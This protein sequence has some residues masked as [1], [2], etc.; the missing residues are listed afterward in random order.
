MNTAHSKEPLTMAGRARPRIN[1]VE[2]MFLTTETID[3]VVKW[4]GGWRAGLVQV[5][6]YSQLRG[7]YG[8][9]TL[10]HYLVKESENPRHFREYSLTE[11]NSTFTVDGGEN[12]TS[13]T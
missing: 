5:E 3:E 7:H 6:F 11:F 10:G 9:A 4:C 2:F 12:A 1:Q 13:R 8:K